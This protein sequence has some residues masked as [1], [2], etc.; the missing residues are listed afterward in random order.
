V[1]FL[2]GFGFASVS[3]CGGGSVRSVRSVVRSDL[4]HGFGFGSVSERQ[5][6]QGGGGGLPS[7]PPLIPFRNSPFLTSP[8]RSFL[9]HA[10]LGV[11]FVPV[12]SFRGGVCILEIFYLPVFVKNVRS[13]GC[14]GPF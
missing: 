3:A 2:F 1:A 11:P 9:P 13:M 12:L 10:S 4:G 7:L 6:D 8:I 14:I 5:S